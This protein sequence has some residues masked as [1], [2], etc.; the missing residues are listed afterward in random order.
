MTFVQNC[1][2][3]VYTAVHWQ[4]NWSSVRIN[5]P[6]NPEI[7]LL[8]LDWL[9]HIFTSCR[10]GSAR[11]SARPSC[12]PAGSHNRLGELYCYKL[13]IMVGVQIRKFTNNIIKMYL[14]IK[15]I[16]FNVCHMQF[17]LLATMRNKCL[18]AYLATGLSHKHSPPSDRRSC[19]Q[20]RDHHGACQSYRA[21]P[22]W[23]HPASELAWVLT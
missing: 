11:H 5:M 13:S 18:R 9:L 2:L 4:S 15:Y 3:F 16:V 8:N 12:Q 6:D 7:T 22:A 23:T 20:R 17:R 10:S 21:D 14:T 19:L 1:I